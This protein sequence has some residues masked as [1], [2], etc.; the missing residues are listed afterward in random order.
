MKYKSNNFQDKAKY[1]VLHVFNNTRE[2]IIVVQDIKDPYVHV[3]M[4]K[5]INISKEEK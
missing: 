4:D 5:T 3:D 1:Y 2:I